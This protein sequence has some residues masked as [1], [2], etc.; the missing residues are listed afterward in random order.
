[1]T[2][3]TDDIEEEVMRWIRVR[4]L[5]HR[6]CYLLWRRLAQRLEF[7][8]LPPPDER[9]GHLTYRDLYEIAAAHA[10]DREHY[11]GLGRHP[12]DRHLYYTRLV[13]LLRAYLNEEARYLGA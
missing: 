13:T 9:R 6:L 10:F 2:R 1:M 4:G 3:S 8:A 5:R 11:R 12:E 7:E